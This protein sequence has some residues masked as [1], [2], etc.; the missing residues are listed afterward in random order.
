MPLAIGSGKRIVGSSRR[1]GT[2]RRGTGDPLVGTS[3]A[4]HGRRI[5]V[6]RRLVLVEGEGLLEIADANIE[7]GVHPVDLGVDGVVVVAHGADQEGVVEGDCPRVVRLVAEGARRRGRDRVRRV[8][9]V[10]GVLVVG[11]H[12]IVPGDAAGDVGPV[13]A[14]RR[15]VRVEPVLGVSAAVCEGALVGVG[16]VVDRHAGHDAEVGVVGDDGGAVR[17]GV[18]EDGGPDAPLRAVDGDGIGAGGFEGCLGAG[19]SGHAHEAG[20]G[21][22]GQRGGDEAAHGVAAGAPRA[23]S[24][25]GQVPARHGIVPV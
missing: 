19:G 6:V 11:G 5:R 14:A 18:V 25:A 24:S 22:A 15:R 8:F 17:A 7:G 4:P 10:V 23:R 12:V 16:G 21:E 1:A 20:Q 9:T 13:V 3:L 2:R